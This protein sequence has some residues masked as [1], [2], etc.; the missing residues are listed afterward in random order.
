MINGK[1]RATRTESTR[2]LI[3]YLYGWVW[4]LPT[5]SQSRTGRATPV[6]T[7]V[8]TFERN[9]TVN[10]LVVPVHEKAGAR[11]GLEWLRKFE[12]EAGPGPG[13]QCARSG[14]GSIAPHCSHRRQVGVRTRLDETIN[15]VPV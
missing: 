14:F 6:T 11:S 8:E 13:R 3:D 4:R 2:N 15:I 12:R 10:E 5:E 7:I 1:N 9:R